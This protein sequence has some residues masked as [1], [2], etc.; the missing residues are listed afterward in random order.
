MS[1][2]THAGVST[3]NGTVKA[4]FANDALRVKVLEKNGHK[5]VDLI[6]LKEAMTKEDAVAYLISINFANGD[7]T[8]QA[9]LEAEVDKR[10][11]KPKAVKAPGVT[12]TA[13]ATKSKP[14]LDAIAARAK[15]VKTA[16]ESLKPKSTLTK[17]QVEA[18]LADLEDAPF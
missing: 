11:D 14:S 13:K 6:E 17:A 5:N 10:S 8:V 15:A 18:Q 7:A 2:F 9:A 1:K 16:A 12:K 3:L 4:R